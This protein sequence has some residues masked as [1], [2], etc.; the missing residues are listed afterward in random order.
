MATGE[1]LQTLVFVIKVFVLGALPTVSFFT[2]YNAAICLAASNRQNI[3]VCGLTAESCGI[4]TF[5]SVL[6][7]SIFKA[8]V[9]PS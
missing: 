2:T 5:R 1:T 7:A 4:G 3:Q 9:L 6:V 8:F